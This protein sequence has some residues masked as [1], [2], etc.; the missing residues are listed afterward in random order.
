MREIYCRFYVNDTYWVS[1][2]AYITEWY[3]LTADAF[4]MINGA[5]GAPAAVLL[6]L[7]DAAFGPPR[8]VPL[9]SPLSALALMIQFAWGLVGRWWQG[10]RRRRCRRYTHG[11]TYCAGALAC[12]DVAVTARRSAQVRFESLRLLSAGECRQCLSCQ[13]VAG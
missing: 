12:M 9:C 6:L 4:Q 10:W 3:N 1:D 13:S 7:C 11:L 5:D 8:G 2:Q